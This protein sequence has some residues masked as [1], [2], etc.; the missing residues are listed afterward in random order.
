[1]PGLYLH[2]PFCVRRCLYCDFYIVPL[3]EGTLPKRLRDFR[4]LKHRGFLRALEAELRALPSAFRPETL[5]V[6]GGTPTEL[7]LEDLQHLLQLIEDHVDLSKVREFTLEANPGTLDADMVDLIANSAVDRVS[8]GV[9]SFDNPTLEALGRIHNAEEAR[10]SFH[11]LREAGIRNLG[12]DLLFALPQKNEKRDESTL[13]TN[14]EALAELSPEHVSW[15]SLEFEPGTAFTEMRDK[16]FLQEPDGEQADLEYRK[17]RNG[18]RELGYTQYELFSFTRKHPCDHNINYWRGGEF[19]GCGPSAHS[20]S[21]GARWSNPA[22]LTLW[23]QAW[24]HGHPPETVKE[25]LS[26]EAK[27]RERLITELRLTRGIS[28]ATFAAETGFHPRELIPAELLAEWT[29]NNWLADHGDHLKLR[30]PAYLIS[31]ALFREIV[32]SL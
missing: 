28:P 12:V 1:M 6:G 13:Q 3:G 30:P 16:G 18:L 27:A 14:L 31:D 19:M 7:P 26:P 22:D 23:T 21:H 10:Q 4:S 29:R 9:Q 5:Y 11:L 32:P 25:S 17:I 15:Y 2:V 24:L 20:H 8:L